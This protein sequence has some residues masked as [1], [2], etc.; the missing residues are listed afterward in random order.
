MAVFS[1][2][3]DFLY[4]AKVYHCFKS[5]QNRAISSSSTTNPSNIALWDVCL[6]PSSYW[7]HQQLLSTQKTKQWALTTGQRSFLPAMK[8][9]H[10]TCSMALC[11]P[12]LVSCGSSQ[13][14]AFIPIHTHTLKIFLS[15]HCWFHSPRKL[16]FCIKSRWCVHSFFLPFAYWRKQ[17]ASLLQ[18]SAFLFCIPHIGEQTSCQN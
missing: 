2:D 6:P 4:R 18:T 9:M 10:K 11:R 14:E 1:V 5:F 8:S 3:W 13:T 15:S 16:M 12:L 17:A 7:V